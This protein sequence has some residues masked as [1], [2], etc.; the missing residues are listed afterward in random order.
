[1]R[2]A[3]PGSKLFHTIVVVGLS[4]AATECGSTERGPATADGAPPSPD[5]FA[6]DAPQD[7]A[8]DVGQAATHVEAGPLDPEVAAD[9]G[10][11]GDACMQLCCR[12]GAWSLVPC[13][14]CPGV[15][16]CYV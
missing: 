15:W 9:A 6:D 4:F 3:S 13:G 14:T 1:M 10:G 12:P 11:S 8:S 16:P 5:G 7:A 2:P